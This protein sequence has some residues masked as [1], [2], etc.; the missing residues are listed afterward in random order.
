MYIQ[1]SILK[2]CVH[3]SAK[4]IKEIKNRL[5]YSNAYMI[6]YIVI[7]VR[8]IIGIRVIGFYRM[9]WQWLNR[10]FGLLHRVRQ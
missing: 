4:H 5:T 7:M 9:G 10:N 2:P 6:T 1:L 3:Y 8:L